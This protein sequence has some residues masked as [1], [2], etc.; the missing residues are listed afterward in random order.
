MFP[1]RRTGPGWPLVQRFSLA[2]GL[3][4]LG[5]LVVYVERGGYRDAYGGA[6][7]V[8]DCLY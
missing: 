3:L 8:L 4:G 5:T 7:S 6:M 1:G 2:M